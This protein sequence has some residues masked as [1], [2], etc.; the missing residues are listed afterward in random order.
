MTIS[1]LELLAKA[2]FASV[3]AGEKIM[4]V[5]DGD[6][7]IEFKDDASPLTIADKISNE[8]ILDHLA[9]TQLSVLSE[10]GKTIPYEIR[11]NWKQFWMID[12]LD[13][14]KEFIK[15]NGEFTV[16]IALI[17]NQNAAMGVIYSQVPDVLY[18][19]CPEIGSYITSNAI[20]VLK[21]ISINKDFIGALLSQSKK[22]PANFNKNQFTVVASRSHLSA[23]TENLIEGLK[24]QHGE[25]NFISKGSS[26][27]ICL[28]AEGVADCYPR[29]APT[30]EWD[31]A[32]GQAIA[33]NAGCEMVIHPSMEKVLYN[34]IDLLNPHFIVTR[35]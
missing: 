35:K 2:I 28:V 8:T 12:P 5:Y 30:M 6:H 3:E 4:E 16:N 18:F 10:E 17:E 19:G 27:K 32:A 1:R 22:I 7:N 11:K 9:S 34:K 24:K 23:E 25:L 14:T 20:S 13:G 31:T 29:L 26:L 33:I 15:R 21:D